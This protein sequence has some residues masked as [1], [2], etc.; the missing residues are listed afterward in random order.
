MSESSI[1]SP[2]LNITAR[3]PS[4]LE[5]GE[6]RRKPLDHTCMNVW[7]HRCLEALSRDPLWSRNCLPEVKP[8]E[9]VPVHVPGG[10]LDSRGPPTPGRL[11]LPSE[12]KENREE[13][14]STF[15][16]CEYEFSLAAAGA[17][18]KPVQSERTGLTEPRAL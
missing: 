14:A 1:C 11:Q 10:R 3:H 12:S 5:E 2:N 17:A 7:F 6:G 16:P 15:P 18:E 8:E 4:Q 13:H 9:Y